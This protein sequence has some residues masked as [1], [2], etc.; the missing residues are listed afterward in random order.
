ML[1]IAAFG[2]LRAA[3]AVAAPPT[4]ALEPI[5]DPAFSTQRLERPLA[6]PRLLTLK[7]ATSRDF[8][9]CCAEQP[10]CAPVCNENDTC[11]DCVCEDQTCFNAC[12]TYPIFEVYN[13]EVEQLNERGQKLNPTQIFAMGWPV[14]FRATVYNRSTRR[15]APASKGGIYLSRFPGVN[16][17]FPAELPPDQIVKI[18]SFDIP[19]I[20]RA[21][22]C[23]FDGAA[24]RDV[25][26]V[27]ENGIDPALVDPRKFFGPCLITI[28]AND[29]LVTPI[30]QFDIDNTNAQIS[31][32]NQTYDSR[33]VLLHDPPPKRFNSRDC[34]P[35]AFMS[36][37]TILG[38]EFQLL[39][40]EKHPDA[41]M[42]AGGNRTLGSLYDL[43]PRSAMPG[44]LAIVPRVGEWQHARIVVYPDNR[45][46]HWLNGIKVVE[47]VRGSPL[48]KAL[49]ARSKFEKN[50]DFGLAPQARLLLQDHGDRVSFRSIKVR[51]LQ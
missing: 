47:Y 6:T 27:L 45:V 29:T 22:G 9:R 21:T 44:G 20:G 11:E 3:P 36:A 31:V 2:L 49:V 50:A 19:A 34:S 18:A 35:P 48:Y 12:S 42:G 8:P 39:D 23:E 1:T 10:P 17:K 41:K 25:E 16:P 7:N 38:L 43:I 33:A 5:P 30:N 24:E 37:S 4:T 46:E 14:I 15:A 51:T 13:I 40:D 28:L 32:F 26:I